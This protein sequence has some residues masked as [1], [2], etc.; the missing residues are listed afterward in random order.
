MPVYEYR[1]PANGRVVEVRHGMHERLATW[2]ELVAA[3][4]IEPDDTPGDAP[5]TKLL[6]TG[7]ILR[8]E[9]LGSGQ[10]PPCET[11]M[12]CCGGN[13]CGVS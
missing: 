10:A 6:T 12:P 3:A 5:V 2:G 11:G 9:S 13:A 4:G 8:G 7:G 1:C